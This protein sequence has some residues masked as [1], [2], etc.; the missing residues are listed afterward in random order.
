MMTRAEAEAF[1]A[2]LLSLRDG[3]DDQ[4][5]VRAMSLYPAYESL[6][7]RRETV[8]AGFR[9]RYD[10]IMYKTRQPEYTFDGVYAPGVGTESLYERIDIEHRGTI[11]D[12]IPYNGNMELV[13][14]KYYEQDEILYRCT[15]STGQAV[16]HPLSALVGLYVEE[17]K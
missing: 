15:A 2:S 11:D 10:G 6:V 17:V 9:F 7:E 3:A 4:L 1:I 8:S 13:A 5:A 16:Y 14:G 12:P